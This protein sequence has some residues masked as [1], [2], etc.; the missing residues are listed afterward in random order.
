ME[1]RK[2]GKSEIKLSEISL[3]CWVMGG[4]YWG[5][6]QD[7]ESI[8]AIH[9]A[10]DSGVNFIDT[11]EL[12]GWG[13]S[14][15]IVGKAL[16]GK[17]YGVRIASKVWKTNMRKAD[18][19]KAF[20]ASLKRLQTDYMD[21]YFIHYPNDEIPL[22]ETMEAMLLLKKQ[23]KILEIGV[24]NFNK[25]QMKEALKLGRFEVMQ[26]CYSLL[27]RF[28]E[29]DVLPFCVENEIGVVAYSPLAQGI[30]TGKFNKDWTFKEGDGRKNVPLFANERFVDCLEVAE[31]LKPF[32][33][34]YNKTQGQIAINWVTS[35]PGITSAIVGARNIAQMKEN[36]GASGFRL[37]RDELKAM[38]EF[39]RE[40][41][42]KLPKFDNFFSN[43]IIE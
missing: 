4:D 21:I 19:I 5:G 1:Y 11:A 15:E 33:Q 36:S 31:K 34:K 20:E 2:M 10:I 32:A 9:E 41:T 26:P 29:K 37:D 43:K 6:A 23:G 38:D 8:D 7:Q 13:K 24:S 22:E 30:L 14:E 12:Y 42:D 25:E 27:W 39:G 18:V 35:Q 16:K 17:R 28:V 40:V 3:G